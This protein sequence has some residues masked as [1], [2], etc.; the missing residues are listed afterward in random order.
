MFLYLPGSEP[1]DFNSMVLVGLVLF[2]LFSVLKCIFFILCCPFW[3]S[4]NMTYDDAMVLYIS[5]LML[6]WLLS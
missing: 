3:V 5:L 4:V 1:R 2:Y 6:A